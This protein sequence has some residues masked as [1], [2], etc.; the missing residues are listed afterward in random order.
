MNFEVASRNFTE[1]E[2]MIVEGELRRDV[3][4]RVSRMPVTPFGIPKLATDIFIMSPLFHLPKSIS[5][6]NNV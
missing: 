6:L 4:S 3:S 2:E 5:Y 1:L